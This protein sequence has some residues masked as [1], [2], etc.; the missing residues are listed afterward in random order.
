MEDVASNWIGSDLHLVAILLMT[1]LVLLTFVSIAGA[2]SNNIDDIIKPGTILEGTYTVFNFRSYT[3]SYTDYNASLTIIITD[4]EGMEFKGTIDSQSQSP[5]YHIGGKI[6]GT[7]YPSSNKVWFTPYEATTSSNG[8]TLLLNIPYYAELKHGIL[9]GYA[10]DSDGEMI[11]TFST[12]VKSSLS[13]W[14]STSSSTETS[15]SKSQTI[16]NEQLQSH[17]DNNINVNP[18]ITVNPDVIVSPNTP[19][20]QHEDKSFLQKVI[21]TLNEG[22]FVTIVGG[23]AVLIIY[24]VIWGRKKRNEL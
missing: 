9:S 20:V 23:L 11:G 7:I 17:S 12:H 3:D 15:S 8:V 24:E 19:T 18:N 1:A 21:N 13:Q 10:Y 16:T 6:K 14:E 22:L 2:D 5:D 4:V